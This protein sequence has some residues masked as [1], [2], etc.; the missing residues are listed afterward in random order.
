M[1]DPVKTLHKRSATR[2]E[3]R[4]ALASALGLPLPTWAEA[5]DDLNTRCRARFCWAYS[6]ATHNATYRFQP[7]D[8]KALDALV[9]KITDAT[10]EKNPEATTDDVEKAF[11]WFLN[12]L[13]EWYRSTGFSACILNSKFNE[14]VAAIKNGKGHGKT[15]Q[16]N[17]GVSAEYLAEIA[18]DL[19]GG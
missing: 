19:R 2:D 9:K 17:L 1:T 5:D 3:L 6:I 11:A 15:N 18:G 8:Y 13:P 14:I 10:T 7:K 12:N 4:A 16:P